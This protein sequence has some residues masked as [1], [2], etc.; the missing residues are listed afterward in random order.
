MLN[1]CQHDSL[2][3]LTSAN[4]GRTTIKVEVF[5]ELLP[6]A[7]L[8]EPEFH[9]SCLFVQAELGHQAV[10]QILHGKHVSTKAHWTGPRHVQACGKYVWWSSFW[11]TAWTT[12]WKRI[13]LNAGT[14]DLAAVSNRFKHVNIL[15]CFSVHWSCQNK[16]HILY[17]LMEL[18][19]EDYTTW[20]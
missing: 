16:V 3:Y 12:F 20:S 10:H 18:H 14:I 1:R 4:P 17:R 11:A 15:K 7:S 19:S 8:C 6:C 5:V 13:S 9:V 2:L